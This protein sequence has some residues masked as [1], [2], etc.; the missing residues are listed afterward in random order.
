MVKVGCCG[1]PI[2]KEEYFKK[3]S[4]VELQSTFYEIP[5]KIETVKKWREEAPKDF[6]FTLKAFQ[7]ITHDSKSPT[8]KRLK[9][10]F[11]NPKNYGFFKNTKEVF[12][13]WEMTKEVAKALDSKIVVFQCPASFKPEKENIENF[14]NFF[15]KIKEKN[16]IFVW[17]PRGNWPENLI[18]ELCKELNLVHCVDPFKQKPLF[19]KINYF[20]LHGRDGYNL[21]YKYTK[22]D[23]KNLLKSC[24]KKENYVLFNNLSMFE[25]AQRFQDFF[26]KF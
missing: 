16:F 4:L 21:K 17:E 15:K 5:A 1:F 8:Y 10:K 14:R 7:V 26:H 20:R 23:L 2:N 9:R 19:G 6:E 3:F 22:E 24:N 12:E 18:K 25:D 13:A 11:G